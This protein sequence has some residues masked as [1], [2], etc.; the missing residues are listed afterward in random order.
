MLPR[1][2]R[3]W[4]IL[5]ATSLP[6][7][8]AQGVTVAAPGATASGPGPAVDRT[9]LLVKLAEGTGAILVDGRLSSR[10]DADLDAVARLFALGK[11]E[12]LFTPPVAVLDELHARACEVLPPG[13]RPGHLALWF[14]VRCEHAAAADDLL[15]R[16]QQEPLIQEA[17]REPICRGAS[18]LHAGAPDLGGG[19][20]PPP[21]PLLTHL[22]TY[23]G[24]APID[25]AIRAVH[26]ILGARGQDVRMMMVEGDWVVDHEDVDKLVLANFIGNAPPGG[27]ANGQHGLAGTSIL[28]ADRNCFGITGVA[29]EVTARFVAEGPNFGIANSVIVASLAGQPGDVVVLIEQFLLGQVGPDDWIP[30]EYFTA[31]FDAVLT[32]TANGRIVVCSGANGGRSLDDPRHLRRFDRGYRDS[33]AIMVESCEPAR[34]ARTYYANY[35]SRI[36]V[37]ARGENVLAAGYGTLF[38]GGDVR[39]AYTAG[40]AGTSASTPLVAGAVI[41]LQGMARRQ[42]DRTLTTAELLQLLYT[43]GAQSPDSIGRRLDLLAMART[44]GVID[45]LEIPEPDTL[46]GGFVDVQVSGPPGGGALLFVS[47]GTAALDLGFNRKIHLDLATMQSLGFLALGTGSAT[48]RIDVPNNASLSGTSLYLQAGTFGATPVVHVTNSG[49]MTVL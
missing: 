7:L 2:L 34:L 27:L 3:G 42:L 23:Y 48:V 29:D 31:T 33:G 45:G 30:V 5:I 14:R 44:L 21:T 25:H 20:P 36:D 47:F 11:A 28:C 43:H 18:S 24:P 40:Y 13:R 46:A 19:D 9:A 17:Y 1:P 4:A 8:T 26:G 16:L 37:N 38:W 15:A 32:A 22:Q 10:V 35:G 39:Q 12:P 41:A 49:Q 6:V